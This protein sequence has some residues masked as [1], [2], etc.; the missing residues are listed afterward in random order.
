M[1]SIR[2]TIDIEL[3]KMIL[4]RKILFFLI[5][6]DLFATKYSFIRVFADIEVAAQQGPCWFTRLLRRQPARGF[7]YLARMHEFSWR[8]VGSDHR[9]GGVCVAHAN[10]LVSG[11][12]FHCALLKD[13][14]LRP[15]KR[16]RLDGKPFFI[17]WG[18]FVPKPAGSAVPKVDGDRGAETTHGG[19]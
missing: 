6:G 15:E 9:D 14:P 19:G 2:L 7:V 12:R 16:L 10:A 3:P 8:Q 1:N 18:C 4:R 11:D 17:Q 13:D 5:F